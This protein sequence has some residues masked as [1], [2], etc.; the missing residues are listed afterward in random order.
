MSEERLERA[1]ASK[2]YAE[3][4]ALVADLPAARGQGLTR[5]C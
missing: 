1:Y 4:E 3:W 2:T 5:W